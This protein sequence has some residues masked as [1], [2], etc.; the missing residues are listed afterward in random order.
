MVELAQL[1]FSAPCDQT[2][3]GI[4][5]LTTLTLIAYCRIAPPEPNLHNMHALQLCKAKDGLCTAVRK[6]HT[7]IYKKHRRRTARGSRKWLEE[8]IRPPVAGLISSGGL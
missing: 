3:H 5:T 8:R 4:N 7:Q 2:D 6:L 1:S